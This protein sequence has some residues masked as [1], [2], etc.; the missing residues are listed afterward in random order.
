M[1][2]TRKRLTSEEFYR[3]LSE[4]RA[5]I[6]SVPEEHRAVLRAGADKAQEQHEHMRR[7]SARIDDMVA[8]L[9][10]IVEH[11]KFHLAACRRELR[12]PDP[13]GRFQI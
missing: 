11:T 1:P 10:L 2:E 12:E 9:G 8:D 4:V 7:T 5:K 6:D 13:A 3:Q